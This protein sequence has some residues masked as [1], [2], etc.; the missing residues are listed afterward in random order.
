[1]R[2]DLPQATNGKYTHPPTVQSTEF[3][4]K[5]ALEMIAAMY[6]RGHSAH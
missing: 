1:M 2:R 4:P 6:A 3:I 5:R